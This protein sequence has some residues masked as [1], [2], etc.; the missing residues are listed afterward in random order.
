MKKKTTTTVVVIDDHAVTRM[1]IKYLLEIEESDFKVVGEWSGGEGAA[2]FVLKTKPDVVL[3]DVRMPNKNG[4][5]ALREILLLRPDQKVIMLS[6]SDADNDVYESIKAGAKGYLLKDRDSSEVKTAIRYV[7][8][9]GCYM[10][11]AIQEQLKKREQTGGFT[12]REKQVLEFL[13]QGLTNDGIAEK[14]GLARNTVKMYLKAIFGKLQVNDRVSAV[15]EAVMRGFLR[16]LLVAAALAGAGSASAAVECVRTEFPVAEGNHAVTVRF[17]DATKATR[18]WVKAEGRRLMLGEIDTKPGEFREETFTVNTRTAAMKDGRSVKNYV[19]GDGGALMWDT[20]LTVDVFCD[21][22]APAKPTVAPAADARTVF[23]A[24]DSTV[25]DQE[26]EPW[27][28]WGQALPAFFKAGTAVANYARSG[29]TLGSFKSTNR[30]DKLFAC[31]KPG[32]YLFIQYGHN[33]QKDK[34]DKIGKYTKRLGALVDRAKAAGLKVLV[35]TPMERRRFDKA[36]GPYPTL[37][38]MAEAARGVAAAKGVPVFDLNAVSLR[39]YAALGDAGTKK[40]FN[41]EGKWKDNTHH[42]M[43][44]AWILARLVLDGAR[45]AYPEL[46]ASVRDGYGAYDPEKPDLSVEIPRSSKEIAVKPDEK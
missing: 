14:L 44:G 43:L 2:D 27:G 5:Q 12:V 30:E 13:Q 20:N 26:G 19:K 10:P 32:D 9:G 18:N 42:N 29:H 28:S 1:G 3:L 40:I 22:A 34:K 25:T 7:M 31:A 6:T 4:V 35:I 38:E 45:A 23:L 41:Y 37:A 33:D 16:S 21:G 46:A 24:G 8:E 15:R 39:L 36:G 17:G 11:A